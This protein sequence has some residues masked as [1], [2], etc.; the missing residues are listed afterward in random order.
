M[1]TACQQQGGSG[2]IN[3]TPE[4]KGVVTAV[5]DGDSIV[6]L[7]TNGENVT[8][9][10]LGINAPEQGECF[11][12][13]AK[14][15]LADEIAGRTVIL[16][17]TDTDQFGRTLAH[18]WKDGSHVNLDLVSGGFAMG[19]T[20]DE[21]DPLGGTII[22]AERRA[23]ENGVGLWTGTSCGSAPIPAV[24]IDS[25]NYDPPG[26][27]GNNLDAETIEIVNRGSVYVDLSG[28]VVRDESS[29]NRFTFVDGSG[30]SSGA[31]LTVT[32]ADHGWTPGDGPIWNNDGDM[33]VLLVPDGRVADYRRY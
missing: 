32:S 29:R 24:E 15:H 23:I 20:P 3:G 7:L 26:P 8:V 25:I 31:S 22:E 16:T 13:E 10:L 30:L 5:Q 9:R 1:L 2:E 21:D 33:A 14:Q 19:T 17:D 18:V 6:V 12:Q 28:W 11:H 27:D 4:L